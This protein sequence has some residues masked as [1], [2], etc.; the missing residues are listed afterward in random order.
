VKEFFCFDIPPGGRTIDNR[1]EKV[2]K[3]KD[4]GKKEL[5]G[6]NDFSVK[7][8]SLENTV[9][10]A[11]TNCFLGFLE[12]QHVLYRQMVTETSLPAVVETWGR[13]L[14]RIARAEMMRKRDG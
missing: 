5:V 6:G 8:N 3:K 12:W 13:F 9:P 7:E 1:N 2:M 10:V 4:S 11:R 14:Q